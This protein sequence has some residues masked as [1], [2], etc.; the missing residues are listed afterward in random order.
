MILYLSA[1]TDL[2]DMVIDF[3]EVK[4]ATGEIVSLNWDQSDYGQDDGVFTARYKGVYFDES[5]AN[6]RIAE[7]HWM[8]IV[9]I[10]IYTESEEADKAEIQ[11]TAMEFVDNDASYEAVCLP[12]NISVKECVRT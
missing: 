10:G 5:Y 3:I 7:L 12:F 9:Q 4:L 6:G 2:P 8:K 1:Q 11:I